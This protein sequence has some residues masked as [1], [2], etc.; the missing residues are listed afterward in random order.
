MGTRWLDTLKNRFTTA[1]RSAG[2]SGPRRPARRCW[3]LESLEDR[4]L[5]STNLFM[6]INPAD[7]G[8]GGGGEKLEVNGVLYYHGHDEGDRIGLW[9]TDGTAKGTYLVTNVAFSSMV[10]LNGSLLFVGSDPVN[11]TELWRSDGTE[12]GT[13]LVKDIY[14]GSCG[15]GICSSQP[16]HLTVV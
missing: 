12:K 5:L 6:D 2:R 1:R 11:G 4:C 7:V 9:R 10:N 13:V 8:S 15:T 3:Q 16:R 14:P